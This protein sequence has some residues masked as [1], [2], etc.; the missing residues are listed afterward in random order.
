[1]N[2][3]EKDG[4]I[5]MFQI[6]HL[7]GE[8]M[9]WVLETEEIPGL[10]NRQF[11]PT[12]TKKG[13]PGYLL[14]LDVDPE[15]EAEVIESVAESL[16]IFGYHRFSTKHVFKKG[17]SRVV[18]LVVHAHGR[19]VE[20]SLRL[21]SF[22][23]HKGTERL[24]I[25]ADDLGILHRRIRKELKVSLSPLELKERIDARLKGSRRDRIEIKL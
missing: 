1:M 14:F 18:A 20:T 7:S 24:F 11:I 9:G 21:R 19:T 2:M 12:L 13:R 15:L 16:P 3:E 6:D 10:K 23:F 17:T 8:E 22:S 4:L 5:L 25:E